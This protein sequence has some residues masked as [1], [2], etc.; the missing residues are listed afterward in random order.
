[1]TYHDYVRVEGINDLG[2]V[3]RTRDNMAEVKFNRGL[4]KWVPV[5]DL[6]PR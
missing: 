4:V 1:M 3:L 6:K 5:A 2:V